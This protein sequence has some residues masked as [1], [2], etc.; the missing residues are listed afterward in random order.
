MVFAE[1]TRHNTLKTALVFQEHGAFPWMTVLENVAFGLEMQGLPRREAHQRA[2]EQIERVGLGA[3]AR[4][5]PHTLSVGMC[6]RVGIARALVMDPALLLMDEPF[7]ALDAQTKLVLQ[8]ELLKIWHDNRSS[9]LYVT[10]DIE[11]A[12]LLGDRILVM[13]GRPGRILEDIPVPLKRPRNLLSREQS[14]LQEIKWHIWK[15]IESEVRNS[16]ALSN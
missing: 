7:G 6:Q 4:C 1:S 11:E 10:H 8:D 5:Y 14:T 16:L 3:F 12:A 15:L 9:V 13:S 2:Q